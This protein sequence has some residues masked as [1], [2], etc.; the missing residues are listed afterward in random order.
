MTTYAS[1]QVT[2]FWQLLRGLLRRDVILICCIIFMADVMSGMLSPTF[3]LYAKELGA[4][5]TLIGLLSSVVGLTQLIT[6]LPI[7][8]LS[9][10]YG[11]KFVLV[12]G[13]MAFALALALFAI[14]PNAEFLLL[15]RMVLGI[16]FVGTFSMGVAYVGDI[17]TREERGLAYG[18]YTTAMGI[19]FAVGPLIG[20]AI[21][22]AY[23]TTITYWVTAGFALVGMLVAAWGVRAIR[24][25]QRNPTI[26]AHPLVLLRL[27]FGKLLRNP[28]LVAGSLCNLLMNASYNGAIASFFPVYA[29]QH[30]VTQALINTMFAVRALGSTFARL[31]SG[32]VTSRIPTRVVMVSAL[33]LAMLALFTMSQTENLFWLGALLVVEGV[34]FGMFLPSGQAFTAEHSTPTTHGQVLGFYSMAG[35]L[36]SMVS[37]V[38]LGLI[39]EWWGVRAIFVCTSAA[40]FIGLLLTMYLYA[41]PSADDKG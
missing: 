37:P 12:G 41:R 25:A 10:Q 3:S 20:A 34:A 4:S 38:V 5:L 9:D 35:S 23:N 6:S 1:T 22:E 39:A 32:A 11:R 2:P 30:Q 27:D 18:L 31:P 26:N 7:G 21:T 17:V 14:A 33:A 8:W 13:M 24:P 16:A 28:Q 29:A 36:G 15:G 40:A 19:G